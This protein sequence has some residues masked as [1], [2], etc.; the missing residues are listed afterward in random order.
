MI[1]QPRGEETAEFSP[2]DAARAEF[3]Q[4]KL[5]MGWV[6]KAERLVHP[7][8]PDL[9]LIPDT[10]SGEITMSAKLQRQLDHDKSA[11]WLLELTRT[12]RR[13]PGQR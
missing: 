3:I 13:P 4:D 9:W 7:L 8:D 2:L 6:M 5:T 10:A 11:A 12:R 1:Y